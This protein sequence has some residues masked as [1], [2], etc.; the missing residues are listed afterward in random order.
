MLARLAEISCD[1]A[2]YCQKAESLLLE[3]VPNGLFS[4]KYAIA[5]FAEYG[6]IQLE[7]GDFCCLECVQQ[8]NGAD[9]IT[10]LAVLRVA[11]IE[12]FKDTVLDTEMFEL[13]VG[14]GLEYADREDF[15]SQT[16]EGWITEATG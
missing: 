4:D 10:L 8:H 14:N 13:M 2:P 15:I 7:S 12:K 3:A 5:K 1:N 6:W 9:S 11:A 16:I